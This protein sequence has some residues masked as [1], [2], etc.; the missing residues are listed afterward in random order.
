MYP[1]AKQDKTV[2][3]FTAAGL[4]VALLGVGLFFFFPRKAT[5]ML[6]LV[7]AVIGGIVIPITGAIVKVRRYAH[8][9]EARAFLAERIQSK[10][11]R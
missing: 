11:K 6:G 3:K 8:D 9:P 10:R 4:V 7:A 1:K 5:L 2:F